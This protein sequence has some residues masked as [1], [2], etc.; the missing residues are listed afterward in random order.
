M[1]KAPQECCHLGIRWKKGDNPSPPPP[2]THAHTGLWNLLQFSE[3]IQR[4]FG[5]QGKVARLAETSR[6]SPGAIT[7]R[8]SSGNTRPHGQ[9][10]ISVKAHRP[11]L[12]YHLAPLL[13]PRPSGSTRKLGLSFPHEGDRRRGGQG[14]CSGHA[15]DAMAGKPALPERVL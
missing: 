8:G 10:G 12:H 1:A 5:G 7:A 2:N 4:S 6:V 3:R 9:T 11:F 14:S 13:Y 15:S